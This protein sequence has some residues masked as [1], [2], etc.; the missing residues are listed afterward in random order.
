M[1]WKDTLVCTINRD[2]S[3]GKMECEGAKAIYHR[4]VEKHSLCYTTYPGKGDT[5]SYQE[6]IKSKSYRDI[7]IDKAKYVGHVQ[8]RVGTQLHDL[9]IKYRGIKLEEW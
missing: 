3:A 8:K 7:P 6:V 1:K 2:G 4:S 5:K 9:K